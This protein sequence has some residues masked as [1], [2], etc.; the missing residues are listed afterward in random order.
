MGTLPG[1]CEM[2]RPPVA[3]VIIL[4]GLSQYIQTGICEN[5]ALEDRIE[6]LSEELGIPEWKVRKFL[7][8]MNQQ[9]ERSQTIAEPDNLESDQEQLQPRSIRDESSMRMIRLRRSP[10]DQGL[11]RRNGFPMIRLRRNYLD[12]DNDFEN[13]KTKRG[14]NLKLMRL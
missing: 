7:N 5:P 12:N 6:I 3:L 2:I 4:V 14:G 1:G 9:T 10:F 11:D 13:L 8:I